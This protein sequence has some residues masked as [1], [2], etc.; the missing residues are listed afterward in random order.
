MSRIAPLK[1]EEATADIKEVFEAMQ[2]NMGMVPNVFATMARYPKMLKPMLG[3]RQAIAKE[4]TIDAKL[5]ELA[6]LE[7]SRINRC[8]YCLAHHRQMA[9]AAGVTEEALKAWE[10]GRLIDAFSEKEITVIEYAS[11]VTLDAENVS[12]QLFNKLK[13]YFSES[14]IVN[15]TAIIGFINLFNRFNGA[16]KVD[17]EK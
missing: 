7:A 14:E 1:K 5:R 9:K 6:N 10:E 2:K 17:L 13:S 11:Q 4:S 16:L 8:H 15:L 12:D 3:L